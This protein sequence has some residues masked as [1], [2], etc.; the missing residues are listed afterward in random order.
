MS[1]LADCNISIVNGVFIKQMTFQKKGMVVMSHKHNYD[2][3]TLLAQGMI[4][5]RIG[6]NHPYYY[7]APRIILIKANQT[8]FIEAMENNTVAYCIHAVKGC[9]DLDQAEPLVQGM[10][11]SQLR[12]LA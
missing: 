5:I 9:D 1:E 10:D 11:N 3:Q 4:K 8:H 2:H 6:A 7:R 12:N